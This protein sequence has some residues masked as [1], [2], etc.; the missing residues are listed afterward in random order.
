MN[1][2]DS[3]I[4]DMFLDRNEDAIKEVSEKYGKRIRKI[5]YGITGNVQTSEECENDTYLEAWNRIPPNEPRTYLMAF[6]SR[7]V[8]TISINR[9]TSDHRLKRAAY[10][11]ELSVE[12]EQCLASASS[13]EKDIDDKVLM[14]AI[15]RFLMMQ[16]KKKR[17]IFM[18]RY[19]Y[20]DKTSVIARKFGINESSLRS[21]LCRLREELR[22]YLGKEGIL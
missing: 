20:L 14:E 16:P 10:V 18:R 8:R 2:S 22:D 15:N 6:L 3:M 4:V 12:M 21:M 11:E 1:I 9:V 5:S 19:Y 13:V 17:M 7:I